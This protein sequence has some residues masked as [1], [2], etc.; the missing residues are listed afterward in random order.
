MLLMG[1]LLNAPQGTVNTEEIIATSIFYRAKKDASPRKQNASRQSNMLS[2]AATPRRLFKSLPP[3]SKVSSRCPT[4]VHSLYSSWAEIDRISLEVSRP[5]AARRW[6][7]LPL[8]EKRSHRF[9]WMPAKTFRDG[10][11]RGERTPAQ[12]Q[13]VHAH[14]VIN[15]THLPVPYT[16]G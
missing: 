7:Q 14:A 3:P 4:T 15:R 8:G 16:R 10:P 11:E 2:S 6:A 5:S 12:R 13:L 1:K 9:L